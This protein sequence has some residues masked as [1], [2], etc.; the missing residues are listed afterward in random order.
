MLRARE[1]TLVEFFKGHSELGAPFIRAMKRDN[2]NSLDPRATLSRL[3]VLIMLANWRYDSAPV[4]PKEL[5][6]IG[7]TTTRCVGMGRLKSLSIYKA[8]S[9]PFEGVNG[10]I[11][12]I[13]NTIYRER[14]INCTILNVNPTIIKTL[15]GLRL[16]YITL[17]VED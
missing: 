5:V 12:Y 4:N 9:L 6:L 1:R 11:G 13:P 10:L 8:K 3:P 16:N 15:Y 2:T 14:A 17:F 7:D